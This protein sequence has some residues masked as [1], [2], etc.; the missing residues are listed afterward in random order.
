MFSAATE[1]NGGLLLFNC[2]NILWREEDLYIGAGRVKGGRM[3]AVW[4]ASDVFVSS[5]MF[6]SVF[7]PI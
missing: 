6:R 1:V 5:F 2:R 7:R 4:E 3:I